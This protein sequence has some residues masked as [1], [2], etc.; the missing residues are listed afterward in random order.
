MFVYVYVVV[1]Y[2]SIANGLF[3]SISLFLRKSFFILVE[4]SHFS[5]QEKA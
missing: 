5:F 2:I 1:K 3:W 4:I